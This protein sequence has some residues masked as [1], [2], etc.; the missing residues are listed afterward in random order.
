MTYDADGPGELVIVANNIQDH[1]SCDDALVRLSGANRATQ[2]SGNYLSI[3]DHDGLVVED[4]TGVVVAN[5]VI[6]RI[7]GTAITIGASEETAGVTVHGNSIRKAGTAIRLTGAQFS[8][9][10]IADNA[11]DECAGGIAVD[12]A[13]DT[14][15]IADNT[16]GRHEGSA[17]DLERGDIAGASVANNVVGYDPA[18]DAVQAAFRFGEAGPA[19]AMGNVIDGRGCLECAML[20]DGWETA[21]NVDRR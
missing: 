16:L 20:E 3:S 15:S 14:M 9:V 21:G 4:T 10:S 8:S 2:V 5:N 1:G 11:I 19:S 18:G 7:E 17:I 13:V 6:D 12:A